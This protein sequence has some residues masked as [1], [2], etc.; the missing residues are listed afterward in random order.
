MHTKLK[1]DIGELLVA[2]RLLEKGWNIS[3]PYGENLRYDLIAE[4][5]GIM[6]RVQ[7]KAVKP[8][9]N[10]LQINCRSSNNWSVHNYKVTDFEVLAVAD[11][12]SNNVYFIPSKKIRHRLISLRLKAA[13]NSQSKKINFAEDF[14]NFN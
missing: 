11:L 14:V 9:N 1:G 13:K 10:V 6:K 3:F 12:D 4:R 2:K 5:K 7:V 8:K